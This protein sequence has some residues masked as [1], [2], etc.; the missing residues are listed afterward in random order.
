M[1]SVVVF[2]F[3]QKTAYEMRISDWSSDV[4]S[5]DLSPAADGSEI[6]DTASS[7]RD[8]CPLPQ[9]AHIL[10]RLNAKDRSSGEAYLAAEAH[11]PQ[12]QA[13]LPCADVHQGWARGHHAPP[14]ARS[15]SPVGLTRTS[16][17]K[18]RGHS[19]IATTTLAPEHEVASSLLLTVGPSDE[20]DR[21]STRLNSRQ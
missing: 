8:D 14:C 18:S 4:C 21:K 17:Q 5:S 16:H 3:K 2:F 20:A 6:L 1:L 11:S 19:G 7:T 9:H 10:H 13:G 12:A 15:R